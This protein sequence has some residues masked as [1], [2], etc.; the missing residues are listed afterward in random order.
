V[1]IAD[2]IEWPSKSRAPRLS[3][4]LDPASVAATICDAIAG[5]PTD[6]PSTAFGPT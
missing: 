2:L 1:L 3:M 5:E 4:W 6:L